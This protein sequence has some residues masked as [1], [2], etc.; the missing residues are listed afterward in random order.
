MRTAI[1][2]M[3]EPT[4]RQADAEAKSVAFCGTRGVPANYGGF[5]TAVDEISRY[6]AEGGYNCVVYCRK[7]SASKMLH[8]HE[9]RKLVYVRGSR[10]RALDTFASSFQTG[11]HLFRNRRKY[12]YVFWFNNANF[13]GILLALLARIPMSV[14]TDGLEWR[15]AKWA[16]PFKLYYIICS[17]LICRFCSSVISDSRAIQAYYQKFFFKDTHFIPYGVPRERTFSEEKKLAVL[18]RYGLKP[19]RY[20]LQITRFEPDNMPLHVARA[21]EISQLAEEGFKLLLIGFQHETPYALQVKAKSDKDGVL[22]ANAIYDAEVLAVLRANCFCYVHGN[23][24][25]G[26]NPALLEAMVS[27]PR[28]LAIDVPFSREVLGDVGY[29][30]T[31]DGLVNSFLSTLNSPDQSDAMQTRVRTHYDWGSVARSYMRLAE[32][33]PAD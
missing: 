24:V 14:N 1:I 13:P 26:T 22:V 28:I 18:Q 19:G 5:E 32:R 9:G 25:G 4:R 7:S 20:F 10:I 2:I 6:F 17:F 16:R 23:T 15:R 33:Q 12:S 29:F 30:F 21:F 11:W 27:C 3:P 8:Y 31:P